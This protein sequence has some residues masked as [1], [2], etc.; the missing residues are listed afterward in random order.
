VSWLTPTGRITDIAEIVKDYG[1]VRN[2]GLGLAVVAFLV[3]VARLGSSEQPHE[4][5]K[6]RSLL[7]TSLVVF[8]VLAGD[9]MVARGIA[10]WFHWS[11]SS[12]PAFWQ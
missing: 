4:Q 10:D 7:V 11:Y 6:A 1:L 8:I 5:A 2:L 12:L 3:A 9:R